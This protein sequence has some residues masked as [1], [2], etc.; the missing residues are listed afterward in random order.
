MLAIICV[1]VPAEPP[2]DVAA[3]AR[4]LASVARHHEL[5]L[6]VG[7]A[8][9]SIRLV[10]ELRRQ[11]PTFRFVAVVVDPDVAADLAVVADLVDDGIV[12]VAA[13]VGGPVERSA[14]TLA[15]RLEA[16]AVLRLDGGSGGEPELRVVAGRCLDVAAPSRS[17]R[18]AAVGE[19]AA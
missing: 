8:D 9:A 7:G 5:V 11:L 15:E 13:T 17:R 1:E 19:R 12:A 10:W 14:A 2:A 18:E 4:A 6:A 16:D 3:A